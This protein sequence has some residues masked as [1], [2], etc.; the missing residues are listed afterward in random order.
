MA[1]RVY[2]TVDATKGKLSHTAYKVLE[3]SK[4]FSLVDVHLLT[5]RKHQIRVHFAEQGHPIAGDRK[6]AQQDSYSNRLAL[7]ARSISFTHPFT[8]KPLTF[9]TGV[10][11]EFIRLLRKL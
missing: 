2:S 10:P 5:G 7:H 11:E 1:Q 6:Y 3:E 9:D 4:G 8:H